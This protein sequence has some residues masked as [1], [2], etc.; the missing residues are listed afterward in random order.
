VTTSLGRYPLQVSIPVAWGEM[1]AMGHVNNAVY[2]RWVETA[3]M[4]YFERIG[5]ATRM[6]QGGIG[7]ILARTVID[8]LRPVKYPDTV[9]VEATVT[10]LGGKSFTMAF[11]LQSEA[12]GAEAATGEQVIVV[13]DYRTGRTAPLD[14]ELR[15]AIAAVEGGAPAAGGGPP[16][17]R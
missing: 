6:E 15:E 10:R 17:S 7:P 9:R 1:D 13:Y 2:A 8:F 14:D 5:L 16:L 4:R 12:L 3:R 11:R